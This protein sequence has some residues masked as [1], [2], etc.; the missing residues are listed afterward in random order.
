V[1]EHICGPTTLAASRM[2]L[3]E[4]LLDLA[5]LASRAAPEI[6]Q[7]LGWDLEPPPAT[8]V[9]AIRRERAVQFAGE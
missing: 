9:V 1:E 3:H 2:S 7:T 4:G 5:P 8:V 6:S